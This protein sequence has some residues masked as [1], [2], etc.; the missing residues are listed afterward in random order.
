VPHD[1]GRRVGLH[2]ICRGPHRF[3]G[4]LVD[5]PAE[6]ATRELAVGEIARRYREFVDVFATAARRR[7][8]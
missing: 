7:K 6:K 3:L 4:S 1:R 8:V 2:R 5:W